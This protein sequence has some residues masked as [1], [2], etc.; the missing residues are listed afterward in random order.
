VHRKC[1]SINLEDDL[2]PTPVPLIPNITTTTKP[3]D[4]PI[5][6]KIHARPPS[7]TL[8]PAQRNPHKPPHYLPL[9]Q[10]GRRPTPI[11]ADKDPLAARLHA[12]RPSLPGQNRRSAENTHKSVSRRHNTLLPHGA[13]ALESHGCILPTR[14]GEGGWR[15]TRRSRRLGMV[16]PKRR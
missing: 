4:P 11:T 2:I 9:P 14:H 3:P 1:S 16:A 5:L 8:H 6:A 7:T 10:N 13:A 12:I 15:R